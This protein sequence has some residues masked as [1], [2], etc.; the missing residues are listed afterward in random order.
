MKKQIGVGLILISLVGCAAPEVKQQDLVLKKETLTNQDE[1]LVGTTATMNFGVGKRRESNF[2]SCLPPSPDAIDTEH[3]RESLGLTLPT[4]A[5]EE[6]IS[7]GRSGIEMTGRTPGVLLARE[8]LFRVCEFIMNSDVPLEQA[9]AMYDQAF[10]VLQ[11]VM[12][13]ESEKTSI[14][15]SEAENT[16]QT[17]SATENTSETTSA[18]ENTSQTTSA[19][20]AT[21]TDS[22]QGDATDVVEDSTADWDGTSE[23]SVTNST[24]DSTYNTEDTAQETI[25]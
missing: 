2:Q 3:S 15:I 16:S 18:T 14:T 21:A 20:L 19:T 9:T 12:M 6:S 23:D 4:D 25:Q 5:G 8:I 13:A 7:G 22:T 11:A 10:G 17:T 24:E 1:I